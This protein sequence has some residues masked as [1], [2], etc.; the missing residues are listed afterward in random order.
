MAKLR[1]EILPRPGCVVEFM[2]GN[3]PQLAWVLEESSGKLRALTQTKRE[4]KL[5]AARLLPWTGPQHQDGA[6]R[7]EILEKL[8]AHHARRGTIQAG[9]NVMEIWELAQGELEEAPLEWFAELVFEDPAPDELAAL[10]RALL[11]AKTH[12][13]F[14]PPM[15][16][17]HPADKVEQ[18]LRLEAEERVRERITE[19]G[20]ELFK[21][22]WSARRVPPGLDLPEDVTQGLRELLLQQIAGTADEKTVKLWTGLRKG[23]PDHPHLAL[24]LAQAWGIVPAHHNYLLDEAS[25]EMDDSWSAPLCQEVDALSARVRQESEAPLDT[26]F[27][28]IDSA[29]TRDIDDAFFVERTSQ[30][31]HLSLALARPLGWE[32]GTTLDRAVAQRATSLYLPEGTG[33]MLPHS[34]G[35]NAFSLMAGEVR[36]ALVTD[37]FFDAEGKVLSVTPHIAWVRIAANT[38]YEEA[39]QALDNHTDPMLEAALDLAKNL[40]KKRLKAGASV[41]KRPD[42]EVVLLDAENGNDVEVDIQ[43]KEATP[44]AGL[45][46]SEF[47]ILANSEL[48][49]WAG[50]NGVP[51][52]HR[53]QN[54]ALPSEAQGVFSAP[55]DIYRAV[56]Y[57]APP[58][59]EARPKRHAALAV[60]AYAP[61]TSPIRRYTDLINSV[62]VCSHLRHGK[63]RLTQEEL[64]SMLPGLGAR[65]GQVTKIQR[66]RPRYWKLVYLAKRRKQWHSAVLVEENGPYPSL[67]LPHLQINVRARRALLG[68]KLYPGQRFQLK[69][70]R[71][72]PLTNEI[73][74]AEALEE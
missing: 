29:T 54:I 34:L 8:E 37:F 67:S 1:P 50:E 48:A 32:F 14:R 12:F 4:I 62:Q 41:I 69:F 2:Q 52:L 7:Q 16:E 71:I 13:K 66:F 26:A 28:S 21:S 60:E 45:T 20:R 74:I 73:K 33:H 47:M 61:I 23:L 64:E 51:L 24:L 36:P 25:Y 22:L 72:D 40:F 56:K 30:G 10:G 46:V 3:Q 35:L 42:P 39:E 6:S 18:R 53:T 19:V 15:F 65:I 49:R 58:M 57:M 70:G 68:D 17:I 59:L 31:F 63:A 55:A 5:A 27:V 11:A 9:L 43:L 38:P 44:K